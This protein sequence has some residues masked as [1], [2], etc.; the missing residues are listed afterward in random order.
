MAE[1]KIVELVSWF[2]CGATLNFSITNLL[3][4]FTILQTG[5]RSPPQSRLEQTIFL[6]HQNMPMNDFC[7]YVYA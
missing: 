6:L 5:L 1:T 7:M 2:F 3:F 4:F